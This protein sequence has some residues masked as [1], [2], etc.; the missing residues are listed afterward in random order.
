MEKPALDTGMPS[1]MNSGWF[2]PRIEP[3]P[4]IT[5]RDEPPMLPVWLIATPL[6]LPDSELTTL[7]VCVRT[8]SSPV[9]VC[10]D[11]PMVVFS[12]RMPSAVTV[13]PVSCEA[14]GASAKSTLA[15]PPTMVTD[16]CCILKPMRRAITCCVPVTLASTISV[17]LPSAFDCV[18]NLVVGI[19][20]LAPSIGIPASLRTRPVITVER[21][22]IAGDEYPRRSRRRPQPRTT[23]EPIDWACDVPL[24][25]NGV[26][27]VV[28]ARANVPGARLGTGSPLLSGKSETASGLREQPA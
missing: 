28:T 11:V 24:F 15:A 23:F 18:P 9:S 13:T 6:T 2:S 10:C 16:F 8:S 3:A 7:G 26:G 20:T 25:L 19:V 22:A 12:A 1:T 14:C 4:R 17:K 27:T 5:M 21:C